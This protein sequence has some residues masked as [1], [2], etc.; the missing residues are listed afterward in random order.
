[1]GKIHTITIPNRN[2]P[3][4]RI[5]GGAV[6]LDFVEGSR[7]VRPN[8]F[9]PVAIRYDPDGEIVIV[10]WD[11]PSIFRLIEVEVDS[12]AELSEQLDDSDD[13]E[14]EMSSLHRTMS[15]G[16]EFSAADNGTPFA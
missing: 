10:N 2:K 3:Y 9:K 8:R 13:W 12:A 1:L 11:F 15:T 16:G 4:D 7:P 5:K 14:D 6:P